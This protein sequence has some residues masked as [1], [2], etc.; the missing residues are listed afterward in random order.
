MI[1]VEYVREHYPE[2]FAS[3]SDDQVQDT[4]NF[5]YAVSHIFINKIKNEKESISNP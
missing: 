3:L 5:F 4:L 2:E 1:T